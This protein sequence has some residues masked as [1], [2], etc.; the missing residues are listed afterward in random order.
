MKIEKGLQIS[1]NDK[2]LEDKATLN[3]FLTFP[4]VKKTVKK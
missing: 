2:T 3:Q 4:T 1:N